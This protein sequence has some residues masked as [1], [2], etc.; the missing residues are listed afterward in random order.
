MRAALWWLLPSDGDFR[1]APNGLHY[2][3]ARQGR[4]AVLRG[5]DVTQPLFESR[6]NWIYDPAPPTP[7]RST[8]DHSDTPVHSSNT[9]VNSRDPPVRTSDTQ[10]SAIDISPSS[11][12]PLV[13]P[14][15]KKSRRRRRRR[16]RRS[17]NENSAPRSAAPVT[18][19]ER[20]ANRNSASQRAT[21]HQ[22]A[23]SDPTQM[24]STPVYQEQSF[25]SS[26]LPQ[27]PVPA[28]NRNAAFQFGLDCCRFPGLYKPALPDPTLLE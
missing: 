9:P 8:V 15:P 2:Y 5:G 13:L 17:A 16:N 19:D 3:L 28:T 23:A 24:M 21:Q 11:G 4:R 1:R 18:P 10:A 25:H 12:A 26:H 14:H 6:M 22:S 20:W 7:C 27:P